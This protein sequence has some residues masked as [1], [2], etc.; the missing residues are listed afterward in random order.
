MAAIRGAASSACG[1]LF[2]PV[3]ARESCKQS[4]AGSNSITCYHCQ[5]LFHLC[6]AALNT[7]KTVSLK[8]WA[9]HLQVH[10]RI[11]QKSDGVVLGFREK[12]GLVARGFKL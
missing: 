12:H 1:A 2:Y 7:G 11:K 10:S 4:P 3:I 8:G 6:L 9:L 5:F